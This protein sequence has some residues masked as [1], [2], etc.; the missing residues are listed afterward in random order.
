MVEHKVIKEIVKKS[1]RLK[2]LDKLII[3]SIA[4]LEIEQLPKYMV[5]FHDLKKQI[6]KYVLENP[7]IDLKSI[8]KPEVSSIIQLI[9]AGEP[10]QVEKVLAASSFLKGE[11]DEVDLDE[12]GSD[13]FYSWFCSDDYIRGLCEIGALVISCGEIPANLTK[14]VYEAR[15]CYAFQQYNAVFSLC[16]T[17]LEVCIKDLAA[18]YKLIPPDSGNV[19][20]MKSRN[21]E[22]NELINQLCDANNMFRGVRNQLHR[23]RRE[24]NFI[25][26][27]NRIVKKQEAKDMLKDTLLVIHKVYEMENTRKR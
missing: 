19:R 14:F 2:E 12:L 21:P 11:L 13:L 5:E 22:L 20:Q 4:K 27:G 1:L 9:V 6:K 3:K 26:H 8:E 7:V 10:L 15:D 17:I 25:I 23:I 18:I 16:R 24:T